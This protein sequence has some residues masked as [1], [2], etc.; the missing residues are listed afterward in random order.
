MGEVV[1]EMMPFYGVALLVLIL[2]SYFP[3]FILH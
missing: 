2:M 3:A 1:K